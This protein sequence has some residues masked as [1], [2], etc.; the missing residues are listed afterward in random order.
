MLIVLPGMSCLIGSLS[1]GTQ[2]L[3]LDDGHDDDG[4][5]YLLSP[6]VLS[7]FL[8]RSYFVNNRYS[9]CEVN[10]DASNPATT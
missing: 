1:L 7:D 9:T 2:L 8:F 4:T 5:P 10:N 3:L 6:M